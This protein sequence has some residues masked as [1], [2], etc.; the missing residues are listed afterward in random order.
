MRCHIIRPFDLVT[1]FW[2]Y[3]ISINEQEFLFKGIGTKSVDIEPNSLYK[4]TVSTPGRIYRHSSPTITKNSDEFAEGTQIIIMS[5]FTNWPFAITSVLGLLLILIAGFVLNNLFLMWA[6]VLL[7]SFDTYFFAMKR[8]D[9]FK[10][11]IK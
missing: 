6:V 8:K 10:V 9:F 7:M 1:R 11:T 2:T 3:K 5:K 4:I